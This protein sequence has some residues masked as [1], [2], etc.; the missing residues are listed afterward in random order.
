MWLKCREV[1]SQDH[2]RH[3]CREQSH[4]HP[5]AHTP[6]HIPFKHI[7]THTQRGVAQ[8]L[9]Q[10][11]PCI[12]ATHNILMYAR[13]RTH[14]HTLTGKCGPRSPNQR[15]PCII[16]PHT[17]TYA[18]KH[19]HT[20]AGR[21]GPRSP[22]QRLP[23]IIKPHTHTQTYACI[24]IPYTHLQGGAGQDHHTRLPSG[25]VHHHQAAHQAARG[26]P[27]RQEPASRPGVQRATCVL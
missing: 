4:H 10:R 2:H 24:H 25:Q 1:R 8:D 3:L 15:L 6:T 13:T 26:L 18:C 22:Q 19:I 14:I 16:K 5:A 20:L 23:C 27:R 21:C 9:H 12:I 17:Q 7:H 11:L